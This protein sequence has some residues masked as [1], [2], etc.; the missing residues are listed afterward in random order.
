MSNAPSVSTFRIHAPVLSFRG[1][2]NYLHSTDLYPELIAGAA[3]CGWQVDGAVDI[4]FIRRTATQVAFHFDDRAEIEEG[5]AVVARFTVGVGDET[6]AGRIVATHLPVTDRRPYDE[7]PIWNVAQI[8]DRS[9]SVSVSSG[10]TPIQAVTSSATLLHNT[11]FPVT[12]GKRWLLARLSLLRPLQASDAADISINIQHA[13]AGS[14]TQSHIKTSR[15]ALG[16]MFFIIG[17]A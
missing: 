8:G 10:C 17:A 12:P 1:A 2:R 3:A 11:V 13:V 16:S 5:A 15:G 9:I 7:S 4:R 6:V 14:M